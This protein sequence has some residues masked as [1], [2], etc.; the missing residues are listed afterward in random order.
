[1][2]FFDRFSQPRLILLDGAIGSQLEARGVNTTLPLWS[3]IALLSKDGRRILR[4]I[5][6]EYVQAGAEILTA[7]TFRTNPYTLKKEHLESRAKEL[8]R[9]AVEE[10]RSAC[11]TLMAGVFIAGSVAPVEDCYSPELVPPDQ[12]LLDDHRRHIDHLYA[13]HVDLILIETMNT[14]REAMIALGYSKQT[15]LPVWISFICKD[16]EHLLSGESLEQAIEDC[17][18]LKPDAILINCVEV[19]LMEKNLEALRS[20]TELP[21]GGYAN[22]LKKGSS[23]K[24]EILPQDYAKHVKEW[25]DRFRLK[26]VGGCCGTTPKHIHYLRDLLE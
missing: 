24:F 22:V 19:G 21:I 23:T 16:P 18:H 11:E 5:H 12:E 17:E 1:M 6:S 9:I 4:A 15:Q 20:L 14:I 3:T 25:V 26:I 13:A 8:T 7:N 10:A 2:N